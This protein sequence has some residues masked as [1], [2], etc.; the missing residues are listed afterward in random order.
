MN[1]LGIACTD[2]DI[3]SPVRRVLAAIAERL[4]AWPAAEA[5]LAG[6]LPG[7]SVYLGGD[8]LRPYACHVT[9]GHVCLAGVQPGTL[10]VPPLAADVLAGTY[11]PAAVEYDPGDSRFYTARLRR[12]EPLAQRLDVPHVLLIGLGDAER[13][14]AARLALGVAR[15]AQWLRF[16]HAARVTVVDYNFDADPVAAVTDLLAD[17]VF[18]IVGISVNFGQWAMLEQLATLIAGQTSDAFKLS[19]GV[20]KV[21]YCDRF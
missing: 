18:G 14:R 5:A 8:G 10:P 7:G 1:T 20:E 11:G 2:R 6:A 13:Y 4:T 9:G 12:S 3:Q 21:A 15:L 17:R 16:T 19:S